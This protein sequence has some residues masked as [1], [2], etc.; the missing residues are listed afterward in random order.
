MP[1]TGK[2]L[3]SIS[4][5]LLLVLPSVSAQTSSRH[6]TRK[7]LSQHA[8]LPPAPRG[9][10]PQVPLDQLPAAPP[11]VNYQD[12]RLTIVAQ[13]STLGDILREVRK[14]TGAS[15]E[16]PP[17]AT[18]RVVARLGPA[19]ARDVLAALLNGSSFN[20]VMVGSVADP[21]V[22]SSVALTSR[23]AAGGAQAVANVYQPSPVY[24]PPERTELRPGL[25]RPGGFVPPV[26]QTVP[27]QPGNPQ[28]ANGDDSADDS[29]DADD[30]DQDEAQGQDQNGDTPQ[31]NAG[32]KTPDELMQRLQQQRLQQQQQ[33][34]QQ[35]QPPPPN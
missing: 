31:P 35:G 2:W 12:G 34:Q 16:V 32:P 6:K 33:Q 19:P 26:A 8:V 10:L 17:S 11:Q 29:Q 7:I 9:P 27:P 21:A 4:L 25:G 13:N 14:R 18:E 23:P 15:I 30:S 22:L 24:T 28:A 5:G 3:V 20:Y 1:R